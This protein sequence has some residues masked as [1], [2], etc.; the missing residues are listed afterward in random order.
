[1]KMPFEFVLG[2]Y[3]SLKKQLEDERKQNEEAE[4]NAMGDNSFNVNGYMSQARS[5]MDSMQSQVR[6]PNVSMPSIPH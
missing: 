1:M 6:I 4:K 5:M 2:M 3:T